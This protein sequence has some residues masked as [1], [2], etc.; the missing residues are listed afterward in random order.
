MW[1]ERDKTLS[2][3]AGVNVEGMNGCSLREVALF[4]QYLLP[5]FQI[6]E[7]ETDPETAELLKLFKRQPAPKQLY[8]HHKNMHYSVI[9]YILIYLGVYAYC[10]YCLQGYDIH[11]R[12]Y[13]CILVLTVSHD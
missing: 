12:A 7:Y 8:I 9:P 11:K 3:L 10:K 13:K 6:V 4:Q 2:Q 5:N 1:I